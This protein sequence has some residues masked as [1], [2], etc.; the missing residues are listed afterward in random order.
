MKVFF[1]IVTNLFMCHYHRLKPALSVAESH[2]EIEI[3]KIFHNSP[4]TKIPLVAIVR[5]S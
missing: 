4:Y 1:A 2:I 3:H 5:N